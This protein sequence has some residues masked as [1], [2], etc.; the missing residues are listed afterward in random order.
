MENEYW[1]SVAKFRGFADVESLNRSIPKG[2]SKT[3]LDNVIIEKSYHN[4]DLKEKESREFGEASTEDFGVIFLKDPE[5]SP[6]KDSEA[7]HFRLNKDTTVFHIPQDISKETTVDFFSEGKFWY[8][9]TNAEGGKDWFQSTFSEVNT[10]V[11]ND[12]LEKTLTPG[13]HNTGRQVLIVT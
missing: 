10:L 4:D 3:N 7:I 9:K 2:F 13:G 12:E 8:K 11:A 6:N 1:E 5:S